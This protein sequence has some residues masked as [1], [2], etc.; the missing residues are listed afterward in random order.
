MTSIYRKW[1]TESVYL[2]VQNCVYY[3]DEI[4]LNIFVLQETIFILF[5]IFI[6][7]IIITNKDFMYNKIYSPQMSRPPILIY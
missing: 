7:N 3:I 2:I 1:N 4:R 5:F 6:K